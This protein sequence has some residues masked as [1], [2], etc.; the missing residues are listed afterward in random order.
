M[1]NEKEENKLDITEGN[2]MKEQYEKPSVDLK[3]PGNGNFHGKLQ[4]TF[5]EKYKMPELMKEKLEKVNRSVSSNK[6]KMV[7]KVF[8]PIKVPD[9]VVLQMS[10]M[11]VLRNR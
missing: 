3:T 11:K 5:L 6:I 7:I 1:E 8:S 10:S 4:T 2:T 9:P